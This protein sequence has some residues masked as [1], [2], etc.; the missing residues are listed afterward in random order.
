MTLE[1]RNRAL[2]IL[3]G[4]KIAIRN[5]LVRI[6]VSDATVTY[7][8]LALKYKLD[9]RKEPHRYALN[10]FL[11]GLAEEEHQH[12]RPMLTV[13]VVLADTEI[14]GEGFFKKA[15]L[16]GRYLPGC[17]RGEFWKQEREKVR[18]YKWE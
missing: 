8:N 12:G 7:S 15:Q 5:E 6:A 10:E 9:M 18:T 1:E 3:Q 16:L 11:D 14:S 13:V 2:A 17:D 4:E